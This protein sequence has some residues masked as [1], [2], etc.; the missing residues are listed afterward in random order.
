MKKR[1]VLPLGIGL[2]LI[3][4]KSILT[5]FPGKEK[6]FF[7]DFQGDFPGIKNPPTER[8]VGGLKRFGE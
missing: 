5:H 4:I 6:T 8:P 7:A 2:L 1:Q 3:S